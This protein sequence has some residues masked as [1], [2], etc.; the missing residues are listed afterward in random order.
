[1][2]YYLTSLQEALIYIDEKRIVHILDTTP[3]LKLRIKKI[4]LE[5]S[6]N[7]KV[8]IEKVE[9]IIY[10]AGIAFLKKGRVKKKLNK[11]DPILYNEFKKRMFISGNLRLIM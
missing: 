10:G 7:L 2:S 4:S 9:Y 11:K 3:N 1:M 5:V 6:S 8:D